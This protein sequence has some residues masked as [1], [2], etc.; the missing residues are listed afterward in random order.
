MYF[1]LLEAFDWSKTS[2]EAEP[3]NES[4]SDLQNH[5]DSA[6]NSTTC[7]VVDIKLGSPVL[8][9]GCQLMIVWVERFEDIESFPLKELMSEHRTQTSTQTESSPSDV[10]LVFIH[11]LKTGLYSV[12]LHGNGSSKFSLAVPLVSGSVVSMRSLGFLLREMVINGCHRRRLDSDS[13]PP[14]HIRRKHAISD[15]IHRYRCRRSEPAFYS[16]LFQD[17]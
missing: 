3:L 4:P 1:S 16:A 6:P 11:P 7:P 9:S 10:Q 12:C 2:E 13:A 17:L 8:G 5:P 15:I 14:P